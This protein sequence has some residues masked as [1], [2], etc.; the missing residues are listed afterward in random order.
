M[1]K[2]IR[3][4]VL[5]LIG[6][7]VVF[8]IG[9]GITGKIFWRIRRPTINRGPNITYS[10]GD[11]LFD[12]QEK[13]CYKPYELLEMISDFISASKTNYCETPRPSE[14][15]WGPGG[16]D[17]KSACCAMIGGCEGNP[18]NNAL[19]DSACGTQQ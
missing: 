3:I 15:R 4:L 11:R 7:L 10:W 14:L 6:M 18:K 1:D 2:D 16:G 5:F 12:G 9:E 8:T 13:V 17:Y 19:C